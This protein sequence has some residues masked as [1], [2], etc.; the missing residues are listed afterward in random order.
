MLRW[1]EGEVP[2]VELALDFEATS[3]RALPV[4]PEHTL[5]MTVLPLQERAVVLRQAAQALQPHLLVGRLLPAEESPRCHSLIALGGCTCLGLKGCPYFAARGDM[6]RMLEG[7]AAH[8]VTQWQRRL[9]RP[10]HAIPMADFLGGF[11]P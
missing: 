6:V 9:S 1:R 10:L 4:R 2:Y 7:L 3:G 8:C 11:F 5:R